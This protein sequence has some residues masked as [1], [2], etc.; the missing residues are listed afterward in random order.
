[1]VLPF[2]ATKKEKK[3]VTVS[4]EMDIFGQKHL[5]DFVCASGRDPVKSKGHKTQCQPLSLWVC[6]FQWFWSAATV[7][8]FLTLLS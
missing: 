7:K 6:Q 1:M 8:L 4:S 5:K 2:H 3:K